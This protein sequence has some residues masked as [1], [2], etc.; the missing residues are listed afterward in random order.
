M[1]N[2]VDFF[3]TLVALPDTDVSAWLGG[4]KAQIGEQLV[5]YGKACAEKVGYGGDLQEALFLLDR[6]GLAA[7]AADNPLLSALVWRGRANV[8]QFHERYQES[9]V[10]AGRAAALYAV[11]GTLFD[12]AVARTVEVSVL[13]A[14]ERFAEA[15]QL[16][17]WIRPYFQSRSFLFG[18][19][20]LSGALA[21]VYAMSWQL[22]EALAEYEHAWGLYQQLG[23]ILDA[24]WVR[25]NMGVLANR[26]DNLALAQQCYAEAYPVFAAH[27]DQVMLAKTR[28]NQAQICTRQGQYETALAYLA[29]ARQTLTQLPDSP[30][31]GYADLFEAQT[32]RAL[33]QAD[34]AEFLLRRALALFVRLQ[35]HLA[36]SEMLIELG[37]LLAEVDT[38]QSLEQALTCLEQAEG[39]L[40]EQEMPLL[41]AWV[42]GE[43]GALLLRLGRPHEAAKKGEQALPAFAHADL[44]LRQAQIQALLAECGQ[45]EQPQYAAELYRT[46]LI[47][48]GE[49]LPELSIRCWYGLG[50]LAQARGRSEEAIQAYEKAIAIRDNVRRSLRGHGH[51]AGFLEGRQ[52]VTAALLAA[53]QAESRQSERLL[54]WVER[55]KADVMAELLR[56]QPIDTTISPPLAALLQT[57]ERLRQE[58]DRYA[59]SLHGG[60]GQYLAESRQRGP[61]WLAHDAYQIAGLRALQQQLQYIE[62]QIAREHNTAVG[63]RQG[64]IVTVSQIRALLDEASLFLYYYETGCQLWAL[65]VDGASG[66]VTNHRLDVSLTEIEEK[67]WRARR[68]IA[69]PGLPPATA[70]MRLSYFW[71]RLMAPLASHLVHKERLLIAPHRGLFHIP[72]AAL[73]DE[74]GGHY[75]GERWLTQLTPSATV[76]HLC[77]HY[78]HPPDNV[79]LVGY[80]GEAGTAGL[81][82]DVTTELQ[83]IGQ[84]FPSAA[85]LDGAAATQKNVLAQMTDQAIV[86]LAGHAYYMPAQPLDSG[87]PLAGDRWLRASDLYLRHGHLQGA[88]VVLSGCDTGRG[89]ATGYD[90]LGLNSAFLYAGARGIVSGLWRVDDA[91]T[92]TYMTTFYRAIAAGQETAR[93]LQQAQITLLQRP[94]YATPYYWAP[95]TLTGDS[96]S[97]R[98]PNNGGKT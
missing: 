88:I 70:R 60:Q 39:Y 9:L 64:Q 19:A 16:A 33:Q 45:L 11:H 12:V 84:I 36:A 46:A 22:P 41:L 52:D 30:D 15:I 94:E 37:H 5:L 86:H 67:W 58:C 79:L 73:Y 43:Q 51:Q 76:L 89:R 25:H 14:L 53:L 44:R 24:A 42:R 82:P 54:T 28:Y 71:Q 78:P 50:K 69:Q 91:A 13:G 96:L 72:F 3:T 17:Q 92:A 4:N 61:A 83:H 48:G 68:L 38:P 63:W 26:M 97:Q 1:D 57:R 55:S 85:R 6:T 95:F 93:A 32:R 47:N 49:W 75:L 59:A 31:M 27:R 8:L 74:Q 77:R 35:R 87:M 18:E 40:Q 34:T 10:A 65:T 62:E 23:Q 66:E 21:K 81:L 90:V 80:V 2:S 98:P 29:E 20:R 7:A 56:E